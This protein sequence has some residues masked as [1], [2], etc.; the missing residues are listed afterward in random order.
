ME[1]NDENNTDITKTNNEVL[2]PYIEE[3][4]CQVSLCHKQLLVN[5]LF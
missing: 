1:K 3:L 4:K 5:S 2:S